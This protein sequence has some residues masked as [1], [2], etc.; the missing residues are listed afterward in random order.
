MY[1]S[2]CRHEGTRM[3]LMACLRDAE[4]HAN[5]EAEYPVSDK[6]IQHFRRMVEDFASWL[7]DMALMDEDGYLNE[8]EMDNLCEAMAKGSEDE[9]EDE[10]EWQG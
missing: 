9:E 8:E 7:Q 5:G 3:E 10:E 2:Y 1:M 6:E 4:D